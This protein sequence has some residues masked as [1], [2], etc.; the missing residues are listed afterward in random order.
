MCA[1]INQM[2]EIAHINK[3][4]EKLIK[5]WMPGPLTIILKKKSIISDN[6]TNNKDTIALRMATS[7]E[8]EQVLIEINTPIFMT[9][10][11]KSGEK[12]CT[13]I[14]EIKK[15]FP[16]IDLIIEGEIKYGEASTIVDC[17]KEKIEVIRNGPITEEQLRE[18]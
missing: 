10:A 15:T 14:E 5:K 11:N 13:T 6:M 18:E 9:S 2:K 3:E 8:L 17:S 12:P 16:E 1:N 7:K 4:A